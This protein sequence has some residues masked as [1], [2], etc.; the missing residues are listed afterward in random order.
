MFWNIKKNFKILKKCPVFSIG[1]FTVAVYRYYI[2]KGIYLC[3]VT[4]S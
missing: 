3:V 2:C 1:V 4:G